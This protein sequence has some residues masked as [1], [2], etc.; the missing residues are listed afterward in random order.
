M[1]KWHVSLTTPRRISEATPTC[2]IPRSRGGSVRVSTFGTVP[3]TPFSRFL[4]VATPP[5]E[6]RRPVVLAPSGGTFCEDLMSAEGDG[7]KNSTT[8]TILAR[9]GRQQRG[10]W[11][12]GIKGWGAFSDPDSDPN[13]HGYLGQTRPASGMEYPGMPILCLLYTSD[14]ADD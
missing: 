12:E 1:K 6:E 7:R 2:A 8:P 11:A 9:S 10:S 5:A 14:A 13:L 3:S 4:W